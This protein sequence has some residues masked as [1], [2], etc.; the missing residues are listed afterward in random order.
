MNRKH[1]WGQADIYVGSGKCSQQTIDW[2]TFVHERKENIHTS[3][4]RIPYGN[5]SVHLNNGK[6]YF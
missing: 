3:S 6:K 1:S 2:S 4:V 5:M